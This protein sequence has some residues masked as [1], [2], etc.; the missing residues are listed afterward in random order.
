MGYGSAIIPPQSMYDE[1]NPS[2][3]RKEKNP[4]RSMGYNGIIIDVP[5][6]NL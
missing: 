3:E 4:V 2:A 6:G 5:Q 1:I